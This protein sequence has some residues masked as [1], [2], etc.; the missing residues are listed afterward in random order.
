MTD[1]KYSVSSIGSRIDGFLRTVFDD[2]GF[3]LQFEITDVESGDDDFETPDV[4]VKF[5]GPDV[6]ALLSTLSPK[7]ARAI[8]H[9]HIDGLSVSEAAARAGI[10]ESD[11]KVSVHRGLKTLAA[12][13]RGEDRR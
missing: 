11:V 4:V 6:D 12:R 7:Q 9:T 10:G 13:L 8:R 2:G 1:R 5:T 3:H